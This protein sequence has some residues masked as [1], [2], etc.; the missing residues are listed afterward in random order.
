VRTNFRMPDVLS[1]ALGGGTRVRGVAEDVRLGPDSV[2]F[3]LATRALV[4]GGKDLTTTDVAVRA[5]K[6]RSAIPA[7]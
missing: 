6:R 7:G 1:I 4:F 3:E 5:G 2:G